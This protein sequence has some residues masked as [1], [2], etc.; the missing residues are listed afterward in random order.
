MTT[1]DHFQ[2]T[3]TALKHWAIAQLQDSLAVGILWLIGL[4]IIRVAWAP[5]WAVLASTLQIIPHFGPILGLF[6]PCSP[7]RRVARPAPTSDITCVISALRG[8]AVPSPL[9]GKSRACV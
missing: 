2:I 5:L 6:G 7:R 4:W 8:T 1:A 9:E 3:A